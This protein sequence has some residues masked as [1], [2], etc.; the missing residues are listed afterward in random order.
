M[1]YFIVTTSVLAITFICYYFLLNIIA[2]K[3][4]IESEDDMI[5]ALQKESRNRTHQSVLICA[6]ITVLMIIQFFGLSFL[7]IGGQ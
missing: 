7:K 2:D 5:V 3:Y 1:V 6:F 4:R